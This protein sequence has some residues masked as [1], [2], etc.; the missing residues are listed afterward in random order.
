VSRRRA[1]LIVAAGAAAGAVA[2][3]LVRRR[4]RRPRLVHA[5][6]QGGPLLIA[7]RGGSLLAPENTM[8][9]FHSGLGAWNADMV[10]LDVHAT[11][12]GRC[13]VIHDPTVDR[14]T[15]GTGAVAELTMARL[16]EL[17][18][19]YRFTPDGGITHPFR[20]QGIH[21]PAIEEVLEAFPDARLT[22]EVKSGAAQAPLF[23]AIRRFGAA[24][25]V[26][27]AGMH[28][29]D[30]TLFR[31]YEGAVSASTDDVRAFWMAH[32]LH[33][34]GLVRLNADVVQVPE[35]HEGT[36]V[37]TPRFVRALHAQGVPV[38]VWTVNEEAAMHALL[39]RGVDGIVTDRP[40]LLGLV[41][42]ERTGRSL[43]PGHRMEP[44]PA[45]D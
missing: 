29:V 6:L 44:D 26:I 4:V 17:D 37:V 42:H 35:E 16:A 25:R 28:A 40:D 24:H 3:A 32:R 41:L 21:V 23:A 5:V 45:A 13:V 7:H 12:D 27:A 18:A 39:D 11:A 31:S 20:G 38:H 1:S 2:V 10:E 30:R 36:P 34:A 8:P 19:G 43:A 22:V 15:D 9:A 33:L 14:T